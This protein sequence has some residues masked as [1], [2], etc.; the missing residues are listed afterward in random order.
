MV[1]ADPVAVTDSL[2]DTTLVRRAE[3][4]RKDLE[5]PPREEEKLSTVLE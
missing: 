2:D 5:S 1:S 3:L 4:T